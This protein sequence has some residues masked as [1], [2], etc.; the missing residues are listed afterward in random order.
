V[1]DSDIYNF[2]KTGFMME[3]IVP[4]MVVTRADRRG[5]SKAVQL[6]N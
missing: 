2:D 5:K 6:G 4:G 1:V 3:Q